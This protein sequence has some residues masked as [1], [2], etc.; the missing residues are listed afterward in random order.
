LVQDKSGDNV[1]SRKKISAKRTKKIMV[2]CQSNNNINNEIN[3]DIKKDFAEKSLNEPKMQTIEN[4]DFNLNNKIDKP[5]FEKE[6]NIVIKKEE[7]QTIIEKET[8]KELSK[9]IDKEKI[10][11]NYQEPIK[12]IKK[13]LKNKEK[14]TKTKINFTKQ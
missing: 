10:D 5:L 1:E 7:N 12:K 4:E 11:A 6:D 13:K 9:Q 8:D 3:K 14:K 2:N